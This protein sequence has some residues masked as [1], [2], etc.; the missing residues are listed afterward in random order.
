MSSGPTSDDISLFN[1]VTAFT[2]RVWEETKGIEGTIRDPKIVS[3]ILFRR[4]RGNHKG[5][6]VLWNNQCELEAEILLRAAV[7]T[8]ICIAANSKMPNEFPALLRQD[9]AATVQGQVKLFRDAGKTGIVGKGEAVLRDMDLR[10]LEGKKPE[11]LNLNALAKVSGQPLL[12]RFYKMLSGNSSHVTGLSILRDIQ[13]M[14]ESDQGD[15]FTNPSRHMY[16]NMISGI[17]LLG[18]LEHC[19]F[20]N[21]PQVLEQGQQLKERLNLISARWKNI[22][23]M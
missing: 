3:A 13:E 11:K 22:D 21:N 2:E 5:Y 15:N 6:C 20:I 1:D 4:L 17:T 23:L 16:F 8:A 18:A 19:F 10:L 9:A 14:E 7:E 12:Y